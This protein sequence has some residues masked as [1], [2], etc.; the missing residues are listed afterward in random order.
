MGI[1][2]KHLK[3]KEAAAYKAAGMSTFYEGLKRMFRPAPKVNS[4]AVQPGPLPIALD[5]SLQNPAW[6]PDGSKI[7]FTR[8]RGGYNEGPADVMIY[9]LATKACR[10]IADDGSDN[11]SQPGSTWNKLTGDI[12]FSSDRAGVDTVW[13]TTEASGAPRKLT[14]HTGDAA[15]EPS[16]SP[17]GKRVVYESHAGPLRKGQIVI[18]EIKSQRYETLTEIGTDCRQPNWSPAGDYIVYQ[19]KLTHWELWLYDTSTKM[20]HSHTESLPGD[21]TDATFSP[22]GK[23][24][25]YSGTS[26]SGS[27][28]LMTI[29]VADGRPSTV[30]HGPGYAGAASWSPDG[31]WFAFETSPSDPDGGPGT[32]LAI[33]RAP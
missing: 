13:A 26:A 33:V 11:V 28:G 23:C 24:I 14:S 25:L 31:K 20:H 9:D 2:N 10:A 30:D 17:D 1:E 27:D 6:S 16:L 4:V 12:V 22:D 5:G 7:V 19:R 15:Y 18:C 3:G 8:F 21:K 29:P 32:K